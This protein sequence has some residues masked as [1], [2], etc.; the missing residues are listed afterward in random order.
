MVTINGKWGDIVGETFCDAL[1]E[2]DVVEIEFIDGFF[3]LRDGC[4]DY[5]VAILTPEQLIE[6]ADELRD[7]A[8][9]AIQERGQA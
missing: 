9:K 3:E 2:A 1:K 7:M 6:F 5:F 4:D 8:L